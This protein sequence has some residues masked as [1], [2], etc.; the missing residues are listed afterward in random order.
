MPL[1]STLRGHGGDW[2]PDPAVP[3]QSILVV[4]LV[5]VITFLLLKALPGGPVRAILGTRANDLALVQALTMQLGFNKP[6]WYQYWHWLD[7]L[8]HGNLGFSYQLQ[9]VGAPR[10]WRS[11]CPRRCCWWAW[12]RCSRWS[13]RCRS[14]SSR[15]SGGTKLADYVGTGVLVPVLRDAGVPDR[16]HL[17]Q[18][19]RPGHAHGSPPKARKGRAS[20]SFFTSSTRWCCPSSR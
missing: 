9:P 16:H 18:R 20:S 6:I 7:Q 14:G 11:G 17:D 1:G 12:G 8:L 10:C 19:V 13:S 3:Q 15:R 5:T 2:I 4:W